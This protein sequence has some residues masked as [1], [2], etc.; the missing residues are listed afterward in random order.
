[1][2]E[3][4]NVPWEASL[5]GKPGARGERGIVETMES[6]EVDANVVD[7]AARVN[8]HEAERACG[9]S[10]LTKKHPMLGEVG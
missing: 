5:P 1:M 2:L 7:G 10:D 6:W 4:G 9:E 3:T 8:N